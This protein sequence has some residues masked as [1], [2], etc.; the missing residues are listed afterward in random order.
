MSNLL[1][2]L[3]NNNDFITGVPLQAP[4]MNTT[5]IHAI[6]NP[7]NGMIV[8]NTDTNQLL[9]HSDG[10]WLAIGNS[11]GSG[12]VTSVDTGVGLTGG[13]IT[14]AGVI[15]LADTAV[16]AGNYN[17]ASISVDAQ[18]RI[19]AASNGEGV[20][21][22]VTSG[23]GTI[24]V[25][26][27]PLNPVLALATT[28]VTAGNYNMANINVD[29]QG[30]I[31]GSTSAAPITTGLNQI[32][33][34]GAN[35]GSSL[36][37]TPVEIDDSGNVSNINSLELNSADNSGTISLQG[38][39]NL[40]DNITL[41]LPSD[42]GNGAG[43]QFLNNDGT[44][45]LSW[46]TAFNTINS[47]ES[48]IAI[49]TDTSANPTIDLT[50][51]GIVA[52]TYAYPISITFDSYGRATAAASGGIPT[53][54]GILVLPGGSSGII[55]STS[56]PITVT[57]AKVTVIG[58]GGTGGSTTSNTAVGSGGGAGAT[59]ISYVSDITPATT[60]SVGGMGVKST[61]V[62]NSIS[63]TANPGSSGSTA[64]STTIVAGGIGG[65]ATGGLVN[66]T[67]A[68]GCAA[69]NASTIGSGFG[70]DSFLGAG[71][72]SVVT[73]GNGKTGIYGA[74]GSGAYKSTS[75]RG[76]IGGSGIIIIE[77]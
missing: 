37:S 50:E 63:I 54:H 29:A 31:N 68:S 73:T 66:T 36:L 18:G 47:P 12:T 57:S 44:G 35:N 20:V 75:G 25:G 56:L 67:G 61:F 59:S 49:N 45:Q 40:S 62:T 4:E 13:P 17:M 3:L 71:G 46:S 72:G 24:N 69:S 55:G 5:E 43:N 30:R 8:Y 58:G 15:A 9:N 64:T 7:E 27:D 41:T 14:G 48:T 77:Y 76:G 51:T 70:G 42:N 2:K 6:Q 26:S 21:E 39:N 32:T 60:Y 10:A 11:S 52:Q 33:A 34:W 28:S 1:D 23:D 22:S 16:V 38:G 19:T 53:L 65:L 74:G